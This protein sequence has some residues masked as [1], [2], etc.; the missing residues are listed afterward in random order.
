MTQIQII[1]E[2]LKNTYDLELMGIYDSER[3]S[4]KE[5]FGEGAFSQNANSFEIG[6]LYLYQ[7]RYKIDDDDNVGGEEPNAV[8]MTEDGYEINL[9]VIKT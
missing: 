5:F 8:W 6:Q 2:L 4:P 3:I 7:Y 9:Y 1:N